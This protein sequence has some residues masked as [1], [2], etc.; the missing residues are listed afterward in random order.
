MPMRSL[1]IAAVL[2]AL[3]AGAAPQTQAPSLMNRLEKYCVATKGNA[4]AARRAARADGFVTPPMELIPDLPRDIDDLEV[5]WTVF[6]GGVVMLLTGA[7]NDPSIGMKGDFCAVATL[8][9]N[10]AAVRDMEGW[11]G[12]K[13]P[14]RDGYLMFTEEG[15]RR[16]IIKQDD[17]RALLVAV[18]DDKLRMAGAK[19]EDQMTMLMLVA[20]RL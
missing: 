4:A 17:A 1:F 15:G 18:R 19:S 5:F 14:A 2:T 9:Q 13:L 8:P 20:L 3:A 16:T 11:L 7:A 6:D 10:S 12:A